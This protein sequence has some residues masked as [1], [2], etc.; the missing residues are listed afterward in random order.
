[1]KRTPLFIIPI[2]FILFGAGCF[3]KSSPIPQTNQD[4]QTAQTADHTIP[5][6]T[7]VTPSSTTSVSDVTPTDEPD[8]ITTSSTM[9]WYQGTGCAEVTEWRSTSTAPTFISASAAGMIWETDRL[10]AASG[11]HI[12]LTVRVADATRVDL[13]TIQWME[14]AG[15]AIDAVPMTTRADGQYEIDFI[16]PNFQSF[17]F[18]TTYALHA[19]GKEPHQESF[20]NLLFGQ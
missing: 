12:H 10:V 17:Q 16:Y 9:P 4:Q 19:Y 1:M 15:G 5:E 13:E 8:C 6:T 11:T 7:P 3:S 2:L 18:N 20:V 14:G